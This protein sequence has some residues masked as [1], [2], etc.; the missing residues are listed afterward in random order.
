VGDHVKLTVRPVTHS[1]PSSL[2][3]QRFLYVVR[4][5]RLEVGGGVEGFKEGARRGR[6]SGKAACAG[7]VRCPLCDRSKA[8]NRGGGLRQHLSAVHSATLASVASTDA[9]G[10]AWFQE[11]ARRAD[12]QGVAF[13][14]QGNT[15]GTA[16]AEQAG[17]SSRSLP[18]AHPALLAAKQGKAGE[19]NVWLTEGWEPFTGSNLDAR[20]SSALDWAAGGGH[21]ECVRLLLPLAKGVGCR[22]DGKGPAQWAARHGQEI[23]LRL[24]LEEEGVRAD[25]RT[26]DGTSLLHL[27]CFGGHESTAKLLLSRGAVLLARNSFDCDVG[28]FAAMGG[29]VRIVKWVLERGVPLDRQ[30]CSG[31]TALHKVRRVTHTRV[32]LSWSLW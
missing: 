5:T 4:W 13:G 16:A 14:R 27:A 32:S 21:L 30:Q 25:A 6:A 31:H 11:Q 15:Q 28:H 3:G 9:D 8:Y 29:S 23:V 22:P 18:K 17:A 7:W 26:A 20:G 24:L 12:E 2:A 1:A 10:E 19:L